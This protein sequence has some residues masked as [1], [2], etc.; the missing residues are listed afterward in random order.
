MRLFSLCN[1]F[2]EAQSSVRIYLN[3]LLQGQ[4][5]PNVTCF[6]FV[7]FSERHLSLSIY[8]MVSRMWDSIYK[9]L[10]Y[11]MELNLGCAPSNTVHHCGLLLTLNELKMMLLNFWNH[12]KSNWITKTMHSNWITKT[13]KSYQIYLKISLNKKSARHSNRNHFWQL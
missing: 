9:R 4:M 3:F 2:N 7:S 12:K 8:E 5:V 13:Y 10:F 6:A 1:F 11:T